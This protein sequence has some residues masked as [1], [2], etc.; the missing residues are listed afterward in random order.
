MQQIHSFP[1]FGA[2]AAGRMGTTALEMELVE[3]SLT[4]MVDWTSRPTTFRANQGQLRA[5]VS[6]SGPYTHQANDLRSR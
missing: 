6:V 4:T 1:E 3:G 2:G 5:C